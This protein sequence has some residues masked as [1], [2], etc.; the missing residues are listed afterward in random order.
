MK[1]F[2]TEQ[3]CDTYKWLLHMGSNQHTGTL[4]TGIGSATAV[5]FYNSSVLRLSSFNPQYDVVIKGALSGQGFT[6][7]FQAAHN[8]DNINTTNITVYQL[9][10]TLKC[11]SY[12]KNA[13]IVGKACTVISCSGVNTSSIGRGSSNTDINSG[14]L[15]H[16][17]TTNYT[18]SFNFG[19]GLDTGTTKKINSI[20]FNTSVGSLPG[21]ICTLNSA[22]IQGFV[23]NSTNSTN[24]AVN[25]T[26]YASDNI[27]TFGNIRCSN[28]S[29]ELACG[30]NRCAGTN[31]FSCLGLTILTCTINSASVGVLAL[32]SINSGSLG[33]GLSRTRNSFGGPNHSSGSHSYDS[34]Y[35]G[36]DISNFSRISS[37]AIFTSGCLTN[38]T[39]NVTTFDYN[40]LSILNNRSTFNVVL[41]QQIGIGDNYINWSGESTKTGTNSVS[42]DSVTTYPAQNSFNLFCSMSL[43]GVSNSVS[44]GRQACAS[45]HSRNTVSITNFVGATCGDNSFAYTRCMPSV[46][47]CGSTSFSHTIVGISAAIMACAMIIQNIPTSSAGLPQGHLWRCTADNTLRIVL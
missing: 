28:N 16:Y 18:N 22:S 46:D 5:D 24:L 19:C 34:S 40:S 12:N 26:N 36:C 35:F 42:Y 37:S 9:Q 27:N 33:A 32:S 17:A 41:Y 44:Y 3:V 2:C 13:F 31:S 38:G 14:I 20:N 1:N 29:I 6:S 47:T 39:C 11:Q 23:C 21:G 43:S 4:Y 25:G 15:T 7:R 8:I 30:T 10:S 45:V